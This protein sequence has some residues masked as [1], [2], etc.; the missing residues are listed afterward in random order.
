[1]ADTSYSIQQSLS[2]RKPPRMP[3]CA[4]CR[5]HGMVSWLKGHKRY[6]RWRDCNCAQCTLIAERQR[7]MAAQVALRRQ[8]TQE[9]TMR[10]QIAKKAQAY[11]APLVSPEPQF[12]PGVARTQS[13]K[14]KQPVFSYHRAATQELDMEERKE[15][16]VI[17]PSKS[18]ESYEV[19]I[20]EEPVSPEDFEKDQCSDAEENRKRS[21]S[22][23]EREPEFERRKVPRL[24]PQRIETE[25]F[26]SSLELL[27]RIFPDQSKAI[28]EL[29][30]GACEEDVV[31]AIES[32]LPENSQRPFSLPLSIR[33]YGST[34]FIPCDGNP[35][36]AFS[37]IPKSPSYMFPGA[38]A[39]QSQ[40]LKSPN[41]KSPS[42]P[43]AFQPVHSTCS[44][45]ERS[46]SMADRFQFP[47]VAGYFFNRPSTSSLISLNPAPQRNGAPQLGTRFCRHCGYPSKFGDKFCSDCGKSL[48]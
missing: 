3:K 33:S 32:L 38:L 42:T 21:Y 18:V 30:L 8:Q 22:V 35:K 15:T 19:K 48:E 5:I 2:E 44:P 11:V 26:K 9:E 36:S 24:S 10:V 14:G 16:P 39:A 7:V 20:K 4:R 29:I 47:V 17:T 25:A 27:Q 1:M 41:E 46:P 12:N 13:E 40:S 34:S 37:P 45:P 31:K 28:L 6:C 23:E 43:S